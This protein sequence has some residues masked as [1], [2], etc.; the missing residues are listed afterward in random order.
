MITIEE[1]Q[2]IILAAASPLGPERCTLENAY[3]RV[4]A[5][6]LVAVRRLPNCDNS[7]M[8]G[9]AIAAEDMGKAGSMHDIAFEIAAGDSGVHVLPS[10]QVARIFTGAPLPTGA[11]TV[12]IQENCSLREGRVVVHTYPV[13]HANVRQMGSDLDADEIYLRQGRVLN[14]GDISLCASQGAVEIPVYMRPRVSILT[15]GDEL[16]APDGPEPQRGQVVD[17]N[18]IALRNAVRAIGAEAIAHESIPDQLEDA[19]DVLRNL[20]AD[21]VITTGGASVGRY[22]HIS[23]ALEAVCDSGTGFSKVAVKPGK[24]VHFRRRDR[25]LFFGLPG[26]PVSAIVAY[27]L[28]V[29]PALL[30]LSGHQKCFR[31]WLSARLETALSA[32][33]RRVEFRR[34]HLRNTEGGLTVRVNARQSSGALSSIA[35]QDGLVRVEVGQ[36]TIEA[37]QLVDVYPLSDDVLYRTGC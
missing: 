9:F 11:D 7:A 28:F 29:R 1:A 23:A 33:G 14:A 35:G 26:N 12:I 3:G 21:V 18:S 25:Q 20:T 8:D 2:Q 27:E 32:G 13:A 4:L 5:N 34:A 15:T 24:P 16:I 6:D 37:G 30:S 19:I 22:D 10:G 17:G 31:P 36:G